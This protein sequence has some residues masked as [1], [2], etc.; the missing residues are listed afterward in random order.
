MLILLLKLKA[1]M[2]KGCGE[3]FRFALWFCRCNSKMN[4]DPS[5]P[6]NLT[7]CIAGEPRLQKLIN[8]D[9]RVKKLQILL[10]LEGLN[11]NVVLCCWGSYS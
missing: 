6:Q 2:Y 8:E 1:R 4:F 3:S 11:R 10:K 5:R 7:E 9:K